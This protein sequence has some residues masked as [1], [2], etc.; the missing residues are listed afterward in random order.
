MN[1]EQ[2]EE[3]GNEAFVVHS[4]I[5]ENEKQ[6][7]QLLL[8]NA[9]LIHLMH[10]KGLYKVILG[11]EN[12]PWSGYLTQHELFYSASKVYML[13]KIYLKFIKE[14]ELDPSEIADIPHSKLAN[15]IGV[16]TEE[17]VHEWLTKARTLTSQ[18][19]ND[20]IRVAQG[21]ESYLTCPHRNQ[22]TYDI[23]SSCGF[24]HKK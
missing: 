4:Q 18:D 2:Y 6:R 23:C 21:K 11:D 5:A 16:V 19:F 3:V 14:L 8:E 24:R 17:N 15:L 1:K 12:A 22:V 10:S 9:E 7:R 20:E 13:D